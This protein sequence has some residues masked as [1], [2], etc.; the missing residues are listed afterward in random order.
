VNVMQGMRMALKSILGNKMR[1]LL[2][3]LGIIIGVAAVIALVSIGQGTT[4]Q[5]T[6]QIQGLGTNLLTVNVLGRGSST[7][8]SYDQAIAFA[9]I[10]G[11]KE[12][13]PVN[14]SNASIKYKSSS[15]SSVNVV[16][17]NTDYLTVQDYTLAS[18]RFLGQIDLDYRQKVAILG[19]ETAAELFG[20]DDPIGA[21]IL[22]T[23]KRFKV[24]GLLESKGSTTN[25]SSDEIVMI[26]LTTA[27]RQFQS[28]G[29]RTVYVQV[30]TAEQID[31]VMTELETD[32]SNVFRG[33]TNSYRIFNQEDLLATVSSVSNTLTLALGGIAAISLVVGGIGIMNI[34]LVSVTERT[35][36]IGIRK[37]IGAK[38]RDILFQ[39]LIEAIV[40]SGLGGLVGIAVGLGVAQSVNKFA[41]MDVVYSSH[42][43]MLAFGFSVGIGIIF[44]L[45]PAN[46]AAKLKPIEA[47][48]FE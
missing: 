4:K 10:E 34:M 11:V 33:N 20:E 42:I 38:R 47:L 23:G 2:T 35:R 13:A 43:I 21:Y 28:K 3:M 12:V 48:R 19:S 31:G 16:G 44:G 18:G 24:V 30:E 26:P 15:V 22:I 39:F 8:L 14:S 17:T 7:T 45:F 29:V 32:L 40:L 9:N 36:E 5:I 6:E 25:G 46:K 1:S 37:A 27:E 41:G